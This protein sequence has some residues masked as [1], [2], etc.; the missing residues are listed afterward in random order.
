MAKYCFILLLAVVAVSANEFSE[1]PKSVDNNR[2]FVNEID[3]TLDTFSKYEARDYTVVADS[4]IWRHLW[5]LVQQ[6]LWEV[7]VDE[8]PTLSSDRRPINENA[9]GPWCPVY[10]YHR[11]D[12]VNLL[13]HPV[14]DHVHHHL[15]HKYRHKRAAIGGADD[16]DIKEEGDYSLDDLATSFVIGDDDEDAEVDILTENSDTEPVSSGDTTKVTTATV[17]EEQKLK[18][19]TNGTLHDCRYHSDCTNY[20]KVCCQWKDTERFVCRSPRL[21]V[22]KMR[23]GVLISFPN[24]SRH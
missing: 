5:N 12:D 16:V 2:R 21:Q 4:E 24:W 10:H 17:V 20:G 22:K 8:D 6:P 14:D 13:T 23:S 11:T 1:Q 9:G 18:P 3:E 15:R 19:T 7:A